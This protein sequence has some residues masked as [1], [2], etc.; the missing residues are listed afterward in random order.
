M[1]RDLQAFSRDMVALI[2][3]SGDSGGS[4]D[5]SEKSLRRIDYL[6]PHS[7]NNRVPTQKRVATAWSDEWGQ[8]SRAIRVSYTECPQCPH[9]HHSNWRASSSAG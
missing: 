9:C 1:K 2:K 6:C 3:T 7:Q 8:K 4:G 5:K